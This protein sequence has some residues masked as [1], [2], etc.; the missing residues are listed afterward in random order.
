MTVKTGAAAQAWSTARWS[1][2]TCDERHR[3]GIL[4]LA[5]TWLVYMTLFCQQFFFQAIRWGTLHVKHFF[6]RTRKIYPLRCIATR[7]ENVSM[8]PR[9]P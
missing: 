1:R 8:H 9:R 2:F 6:L 5:P 7:G 4:K 3:G